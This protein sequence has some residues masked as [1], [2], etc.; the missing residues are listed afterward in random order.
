MVDD[1]FDF[2]FVLF[3]NAGLPLDVVD[4]EGGCVLQDLAVLVGQRQVGACAWGGVLIRS[5]LLTL[6]SKNNQFNMS[7]SEAV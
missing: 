6:Q 5:L 7:V 2:V 1:L 3:L 4:D